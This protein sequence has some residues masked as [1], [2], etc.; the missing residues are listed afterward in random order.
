MPRSTREPSRP[1]APA[2]MTPCKGMKG[3][4]KADGIY[5][6]AVLD[7]YG[8]ITRSCAMWD[9]AW[10]SQWVT[11]FDPPEWEPVKCHNCVVTA[12]RNP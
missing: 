6:V 11:L 7:G 8:Q 5:V 4:P 1:K 2:D 12:W 3:Q 9:G 10:W